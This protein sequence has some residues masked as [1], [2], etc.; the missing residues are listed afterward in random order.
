MEPDDRPD[1]ELLAAHVAGD[2]WAFG[3]LIRRHERHLW[4][5]AR[6]TT[7][8]PDDAADALQD[9]LLQAHRTAHRFRGDAQ[10]RTW[11]HRLVVNACLDRLRRRRRTMPLPGGDAPV[12]PARIDHA[13]RLDITSAL[14]ALPP[15]QRAAIVAVDVEG[16]SV[17]DA[18][19][20]LGVAPGTIKSRRARG[21]ATLAITLGHLR[22]A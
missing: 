7:G 2:P 1:T 4:A 18:A 20:R 19:D 3:T 6:R 9:A 12:P 11:L 8:D 16:L 17:V 15:H 10:V 5:V 21:R 13:D 14:A 22:S